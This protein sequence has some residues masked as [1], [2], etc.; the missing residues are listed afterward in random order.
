MPTPF[1]TEPPKGLGVASFSHQSNLLKVARLRIG[2][3]RSQMVKAATQHESAAEAAILSW[4]QTLADLIDSDTA[5]AREQ[6]STLATD[7]HDRSFD[8]SSR[9]EED[10][11]QW[12]ARLHSALVS[13]PSET[14]A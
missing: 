5:D 11:M 3:V 13:W 9:A 4:A 7:M 2:K 6:I 10:I 1:S 12:S 8:Y 14:A